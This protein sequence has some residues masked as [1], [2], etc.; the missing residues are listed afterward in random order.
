[1]DRNADLKRRVGDFIAFSQ[2]NKKNRWRDATLAVMLVVIG[3][4]LYLVMDIKQEQDRRT[5]YV[6][7]KNPHQV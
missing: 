5:P 2:Q 6:Y 7:T 3:L 1:M 4:N